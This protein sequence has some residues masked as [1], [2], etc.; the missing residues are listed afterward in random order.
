MRARGSVD[1]RAPRTLFALALAVIVITVANI[2]CDEGPQFPAKR[3]FT[4]TITL[5]AETVLILDVPISITLRGEP[6]IDEIYATVDATVTA[7]TSTR[8]SQLA[9]DL[10]FIRTSSAGDTKLS[11]ALA[12]PPEASIGGTITVRVPSDLDLAVVERGGTTDVVNMR[13][14][15]EIAS[16]SHTRISGAERNVFVQTSAGNVLVDSTLPAGSSVRLELQVGDVDLAV[17]EGLSAD[18][19]ATAVRSGSV[20]PAHP[21][22]PQFTG[23][24]GDTYRANVGGGLSV[25]R[26]TT[27]SG[28]IIIRGR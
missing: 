25:V 19:Q 6:R 27:G 10:R 5:G 28:K 4:S 7:S 2:S 26:I 16:A 20:I 12:A 15:I 13:G 8:A 24:A 14:N 11:L 22:L 9:E 21:R 1:N 23:K 17:P 3:T 18:I